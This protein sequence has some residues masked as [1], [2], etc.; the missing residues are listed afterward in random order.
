[1]HPMRWRGHGRVGTRRAPPRRLAVLLQD[2]VEGAGEIGDEVV[3][4]LEPDA[5]TDQITG[6]LVAGP[7]RA[8]VGHLAGMLDQALDSP[9]ALGQGEEARAGADLERGRVAPSQGDY[10]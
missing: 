4:G 10:E 5:E 6:D 3:E 9:Q 1:M 7:R 8:G 2:R